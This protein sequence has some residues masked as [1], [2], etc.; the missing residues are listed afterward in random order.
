VWRF[1]LTVLDFPQREMA[2][3]F[4]VRQAPFRLVSAAESIHFLPVVKMAL[5]LLRILCSEAEVERMFT[6]LWRLFGDH[7]QHTRTIWLSRV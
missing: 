7:V 3:Q 1:Y 4:W 2:G 6:H 5:I